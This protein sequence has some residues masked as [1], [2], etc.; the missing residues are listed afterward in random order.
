LQAG[1]ETIKERPKLD[2]EMVSG[3]NSKGTT[4]VEKRFKVKQMFS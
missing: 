3:S 1:L 2:T 4:A